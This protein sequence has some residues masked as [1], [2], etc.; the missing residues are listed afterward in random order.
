MFLQLLMTCMLMQG[1]ININIVH[2]YNS[3]VDATNYT[4]QVDLICSFHLFMVVKIQSLLVLRAF[5]PNH[6]PPV[7]GG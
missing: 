3:L 7:A 2:I 4:S 6:Q 5:G 1:I